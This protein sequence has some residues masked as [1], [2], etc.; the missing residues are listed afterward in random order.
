MIDGIYVALS[1]RLQ[2]KKEITVSH[3]FSS[4]LLLISCSLQ[5][6]SF[7]CAGAPGGS[8]AVGRVDDFMA[9]QQQILQGGALLHEMVVA[10]FALNVQQE[11]NLHKVRQVG[12]ETSN[13]QKKQSW[14]IFF[15][16]LT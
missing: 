15:Q 13:D 16:F 7:F 1:V 3:F 4:N 10:L 11:L 12:R 2:K 14:D 9:L 8:F 6:C 5:I